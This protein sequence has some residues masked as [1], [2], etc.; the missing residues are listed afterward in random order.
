MRAAALG[1]LVVLGLVLASAAEARTI[2]V[3][4]DGQF[5][6]LDVGVETVV[7]PGFDGGGGWGGP[8]FDPATG[9]LYVSATEMACTGMLAP[10]VTGSSGR[11]LYAKEC[12]A[13]HRDDL[14]GRLQNRE[15]VRQHR[16]AARADDFGSRDRRDGPAGLPRW[17]SP[18]I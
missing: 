7:F 5:V 3:R 14:Q 11:Q 4:S 17:S 18:A 16:A 8:A 15:R 13:C 1:A 9:L 10:A 12:A 6:P 2:H